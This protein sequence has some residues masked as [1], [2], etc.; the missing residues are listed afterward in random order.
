M[1]ESMGL[2]A[3]D[4]H[5]Q[6][7]A[8]E[9]LAKRLGQDVAAFVV[10]DPAVTGR[11]AASGAA[12]VATRLPGPSNPAATVGYIQWVSTDP[13]WRRRGMARAITQELVE[14]LRQRGVRSIELHA[15]PDGEAMYRSLG[16]G[17]GQNPGLR[18]RA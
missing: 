16:F 1:Y 10:D 12:S 3:S 4:E 14:W 18:L 2:D 13:R 9:A 6:V 17:Q 7:A 11:L 15:T 8:V 5:W